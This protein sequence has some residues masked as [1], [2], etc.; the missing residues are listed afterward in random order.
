MEI[1]TN[2]PIKEM[3]TMRIG[4]NAKYFIEA[5]TKEEVAEI[6]KKAELRSLKVYAIGSGSNVI[7]KDDGFDGIIMRVCVPGFEII[8]ED[9]D[10]TTIRVGAGEIWDSVVERSV[11]MN[12]SGIEAMSGIPGTAGATPVQNVGAYGQEIA[13]TLE[14][15][16]AYDT[17]IGDFVTIKKSDCKFDYRYSI[18]KG[19]A[20][21]RY[22]ITSITLKL[23][24]DHFQQPLYDSLQRKFEISPADIYTPSM[25]RD[26]VL[27]IRN[28][29][30]PDPKTMP[31]SGS[32]FKNAIVNKYK[33][34]ELKSL[35]PDVPTYDAGNG[36][37]KIPAGWLIE[38]AGM[39]GVLING[40]RVYD[41]NALILIN[42]SATSY[43]DLK[44]AKEEIVK[45]VYDKFGVKIEQEPV[46]I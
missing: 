38:Q 33:F 8:A 46:E 32:F 15:L 9:A 21:G 12:L 42:E 11:T 24:K 44:K 18:F 35:Y 28:S 7:A 13:D 16:E 26:S 45:K 14:S 39:K 17:S 41:K 36:R 29:K 40:I 5:H 3:T 34:D 6:C 31:N 22:I 27:E 20:A 23:S 4:G 37:Y 2:V 19:K 1:K 10:S 30:L 43:E 25:I